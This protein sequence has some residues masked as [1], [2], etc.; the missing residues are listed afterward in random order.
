MG[1]PTPQEYNEAIQNPRSAFADPELKASRPILT[2]M[3]LPR[4]ISG[5]FA[6]VYQ[7]VTEE[8]RTY[9]VRCFLRDYGDHQERYAA[10]SAHLATAQ[11]PYTVDFTFLTEGIRVNQRW[12]PVLKMEWVAGDALDTYIERNLQNPAVLLA[13]AEQW[14]EMIQALR[15]VSIGH[16]DLQHG[17]VMVVDGQ[18]R[19]IDY[20]GMYVPH[21]AGCG[22]HEIGHRN[23]QH[24]GRSERDFGP[25]IDHF[26]TWVVYTS[27][28]AL[29]VDTTWWQRFE[30]G[31]ECLL[32]RRK[33]FLNPEGS[34]VFQALMAAS[35]PRLQN[36]AQAF[37]T[38]LDLPIEQVPPVDGKLR[39]QG[40]AA[41]PVGLPRSDWLE[42]HIR[43]G[44][45][46]SSLTHA[47]DPAP[48]NGNES[49]PVAAGEPAWIEDFL[50]ARLGQKIRF[51]GS[52]GRVRSIVL[53]SLGIVLLLG[54][55]FS[56]GGVG[57]AVPAL[58]TLLT[59][60]VDLGYLAAAY[61]RDPSVLSRQATREGLRGS[62]RKRRKMGGVQ[63]EI[64]RD[65]STIQRVDDR[66]LARLDRAEQRL[67]EGT[68]RAMTR[69][70]QRLDRQ[71]TN[72]AAKERRLQ[73]QEAGEVQRAQEQLAAAQDQL[74][75]ETEALRQAE[76]T[77]LQRALAKRQQ[78][79]VNDFIKRQ[80]I[81]T[82]L[83]TGIGPVVKQRLRDH[84][85]VRA[86]DVEAQ[87]LAKVPGIGEGRM[88]M[89]LNWRTQLEDLARQAAPQ[90]L[91][92][93]EETFRRGKF[94]R[95]RLRI[96]KE[97]IKLKQNGAAKVDAVRRRYVERRKNLASAA[98]AADEQHRGEVDE[99]TRRQAGQRA[100]LQ[101]ERALLDA[102]ADFHRG[103]AQDRAARLDQA[104]RQIAW[105]RAAIERQ[106]VRY[107]GLEFGNYLKEI[108]MIFPTS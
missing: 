73:Q 6:S 34:P 22:S 70:A 67:Q 17:N 16:G 30:A 100:A 68:Q 20:D 31:D 64:E 81:E 92:K 58:L 106:L 10:I 40:L 104:I 74:R 4:P 35:D 66:Q 84:G 103:E 56:A 91:S 95:R 46:R 82:A 48:D 27:L 44:A 102:T 77:D 99:I 94:L 62:E 42:D 51:Q 71:R 53:G 79:F 55:G 12:F 90:N 50:G 38:L 72:L 86:K 37:R 11:L 97:N 28:V 107:E 33:D 36:L 32:F 43:G 88:D 76:A 98:Q 1:W 52:A 96:E 49:S 25:Q 39:A 45:P 2:P 75:K 105:Q 26:S 63:A 59:L 101:Q 60:A 3:G 9:A 18:L 78:Q 24:P 57:L 21:L 8:Q 83:I 89:L 87:R 29:A 41:K 69:A 14:V 80:T 23:Y 61:N 5:G 13:L 85:I 19:L 7:L 108:M 47:M 93:I 65:L 15:R 54:L